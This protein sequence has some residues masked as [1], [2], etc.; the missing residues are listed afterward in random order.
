MPMGA[1]EDFDSALGGGRLGA[2][3]AP[4]GDSAKHQRSSSGVPPPRTTPLRVDVVGDWGDWLFNQPSWQPLS[5][6]TID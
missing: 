1:R 3:V 4:F 2:L 5:S 6:P